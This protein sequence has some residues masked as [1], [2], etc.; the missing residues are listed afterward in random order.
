MCMDSVAVQEIGELF[1]LC[2]LYGEWE[3]CSILFEVE[4]PTVVLITPPKMGVTMR[5]MKFRNK[6]NGD[7]GGVLLTQQVTANLNLSFGDQN[8][9]T[10]IN[11]S[12]I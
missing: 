3:L 5:K 2:Q 8:L 4:N 11:Y 9:T 7:S 10:D 1:V 6:K 12:K